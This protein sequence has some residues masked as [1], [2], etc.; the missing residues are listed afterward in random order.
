MKIILSSFQ[1]VPD[2]AGYESFIPKAILWTYFQIIRDTNLQVSGAPHLLKNL[3]TQ[4]LIIRK[5]GP[6]YDPV[7][8]FSFFSPKVLKM[9]SSKI[10]ASVPELKLTEVNIFCVTFF[11]CLYSLQQECK[12]KAIV[13][14]E[15]ITLLSVSWITEI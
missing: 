13:S 2:G 11:H 12:K 1:I 7:D 8:E 3:G 5:A 15:L 10:C 14:N 9:I 6:V 4:K